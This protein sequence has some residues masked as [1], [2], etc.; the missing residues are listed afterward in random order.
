M[1]EVADCTNKVHTRGHCLR[2]YREFVGTDALPYLRVPKDKGV[3]PCVIDDCDAKV[4]AKGL[5][6]THY[7]RNRRTGSPDGIRAVTPPPPHGT[8]RRHARGCRCEPCREA[9]RQ[10][11]KEWAARALER[12]ECGRPTKYYAGCR[13]EACRESAKVAKLEHPHGTYL[14]YLGGCRCDECKAEYSRYKREYYA[15]NKDY[16]HKQRVR[17]QR[18]NHEQANV[19]QD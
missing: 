7:E 9:N 16:R 6:R 2:H 13:C 4:Y 10:Y 5:C 11:R 3:G 15:R 8:N 19:Q 18:R 17:T 1:C 14:R 12:M